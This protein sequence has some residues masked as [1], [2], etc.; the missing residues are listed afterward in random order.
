MRFFI[1]ILLCFIILVSLGCTKE[2]EVFK[3]KYRNDI[4]LAVGYDVVIEDIKFSE[5]AGVNEMDLPVYI[6]ENNNKSY[7][8]NYLLTLAM[9]NDTGVF[10]NIDPN[11]QEKL[12]LHRA[13]LDENGFGQII[14]WKEVD[15]IF[16][17]FSKAQVIDVETGLRFNV[18]RRGGNQHVDVQPL[19]KKDT[20]IMFQS[21]DRQWSWDRRAVVLRVG[22]DF[23]A[24]SMNGMPHG[25]GAIRDNEFDG[26]FCIHF[27]QSRTH[28]GN[29]LDFAHQLMIKKAGG[30]LF[31]YLM[32]LEPEG[33]L[34]A[35]LIFT[36]QRQS[37]LAEFVLFDKN[38]NISFFETMDSVNIVSVSKLENSTDYQ[39]YEVDLIYYKDNQRYRENLLFDF[40][41]LPN[42]HTWKIK[43]IH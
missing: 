5:I 34:R 41:K 3:L 1:V 4:N 39:K 6:L 36:T 13:L 43:Y 27:Y 40:Y 8:I 21:F 2:V 35:F 29:N 31:E 17:K 14:P 42:H 38:E 9:D 33:I 16:P 28:G 19:T 12:K 18:Q 32:E 11:T 20:E 10:F 15:D 37:Q 25:A 7:T 30:N 26:H 24:G 22:V 23:I